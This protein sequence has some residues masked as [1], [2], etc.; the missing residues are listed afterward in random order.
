MNRNFETCTIAVLVILAFAACDKSDS[1]GD[2]ASRTAVSIAQASTYLQ[3]LSAAAEDTAS[4]RARHV[5]RLKAQVRAVRNRHGLDIALMRRTG[6]ATNLDHK[7]AILQWVIEARATAHGMSVEEFTTATREGSFDLISTNIKAV[8]DDLENL[9]HKTQGLIQVA[10]SLVEL[11]KKDDVNAQARYLFLH[12]S[13][14]RLELDARMIES[15]AMA[16]R[17]KANADDATSGARVAVANQDCRRRYRWGHSGLRR[18]AGESSSR[19]RETVPSNETGS[20]RRE[21][22]SFGWGTWIR[23]R[24]I[25]VRAGGSTVNLSPKTPPKRWCAGPPVPRPAYR[26]SHSSARWSSPRGA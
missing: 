3:T 26:R 20:H 24:T 7:D 9:D 4:T 2:L 14:I 22:V 21:P 12:L 10:N 17:A 15:R 8:M 13:E 25:R 11:S 19:S 6:D 1:A 18:R 16:K 23:T 5:A